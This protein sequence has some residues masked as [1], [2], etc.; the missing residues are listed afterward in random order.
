MIVPL[1]NISF[2]G[3]LDVFSQYFE[4][5]ILDNKNQRCFIF[6]KHEMELNGELS[7]SIF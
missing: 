5:Q 2:V 3:N 4:K 6:G 1:K 7:R